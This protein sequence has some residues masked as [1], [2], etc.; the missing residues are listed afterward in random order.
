M[1]AA[2]SPPQF[3][4][5]FSSHSGDY[6][7]FRPRYPGSLFA[8]LADNASARRAV[9]DVGCGNGQASGDLA[10]CFDT[11][12]ATD[13]SAEQIAAALPHPKIDYRVAPAEAS[14]LANASV[15]AVIVCQALHWFDFDQFYREVRRVARA[16]APIFAVAYEL[17]EISPRIDA[18]I[19][20]F[21]KADIGPFWPADRVHIETGYRDIPWPFARLDLPE[22]RMSALW[23]LD[24]LTGYVSTWSAV[25]RYH[26]AT[27]NDVVPALRDALLP[28]WGTAP[29]EISWPLV[30]KAGR[31]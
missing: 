5:Y 26:A 1:D 6:A 13:A 19:R 30:I 29:R 2:P 7:G 12:H 24:Q 9:W 23:S 16:G 11:V 21:Y 31:V 10:R 14:G 8:L 22:V 15:D 25:R 3:K 28:H 20:D 17:A 4:D 27:S 18:I